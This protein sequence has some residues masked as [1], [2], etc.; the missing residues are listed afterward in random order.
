MNQ[1]KSTKPPSGRGALLLSLIGFLTI[2]LFPLGL[3]GALLGF[4]AKKRRAELGH[5]ASGA[6]WTA[7]VVGLLSPLPAL[8]MFLFMNEQD[9]ALQELVDSVADRRSGETLEQEVA[10]TLASAFAGSTELLEC[11]T[12]LVTR[13]SRAVLA[14]VAVPS[15]EGSEQVTKTVTF[16]FAKTKRWFVLEQKTEGECSTREMSADIEGLPSGDSPEQLERAESLYREDEQEFARILRIVELRHAFTKLASVVDQAKP[17]AQACPDWGAYTKGKS[18]EVAHIERSRLTNFKTDRSKEE[19]AWDFMTQEQLG[20]LLSNDSKLFASDAAQLLARLETR[21]LL[22]VFAPNGEDEKSLPRV[23]TGGFFGGTYDGT[24]YLADWSKGTILC[25]QPLFFE[26]GDEV[27]VRRGRLGVT[28][29]SSI[30]QKI[31]AQFIENFEDAAL[32]RVK[33]MS[34]DV[35]KLNL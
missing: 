34:G 17:G 5:E 14:D 3:W 4:K 31:Q 6:V 10:C 1:N 24:V 7:I 33:E 27:T 21:P 11:K 8:G 22:V 9:K 23:T 30:D 15:F 32:A 35:L 20:L 13:G 26:N 19:K 18:L 16:C 2:F 25:A 12:P 28:A 29:N